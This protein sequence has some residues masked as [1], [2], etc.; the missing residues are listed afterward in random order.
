MSERDGD[1]EGLGPR[2]TIIIGAPIRKPRVQQ[3]TTQPFS[4]ISPRAGS[5][6]VGGLR[7]PRL[8]LPDSGLGS[9]GTPTDS[10]G[11]EKLFP[12]PAVP[13]DHQDLG[14]ADDS[15]S[16]TTLTFRATPGPGGSYSQL[17]SPY[18]EEELFAAAADIQS[19]YRRFRAQKLLSARRKIIRGYLDERQPDRVSYVIPLQSVF[20]RW[21]ATAHLKR[22]QEAIATYLLDLHRHVYV[23]PPADVAARSIRR[24][25]NFLRALV[26]RHRMRRQRLE[27]WRH[28]CILGIAA[29]PRIVPSPIPSAVPSPAARS[30]K[31]KGPEVF[32]MSQQAEEV[33][34][35]PLAEHRKRRDHSWSIFAPLEDAAWAVN[36][37]CL[38]TLEA[39]RQEALWVWEAYS[40]KKLTAIARRLQRW[41]RIQS[42]V[43]AARRHWNLSR[44]TVMKGE[45]D[46]THERC[47]IG[48]GH[49]LET[50]DIERCI[51]QLHEA[52]HRATL[53]Q[54]AD[55][56]AKDRR[57]L[58]E[59]MKL[60]Q[61]TRRDGVVLE[62]ETFLKDEVWPLRVQLLGLMA[63][64]GSLAIISHRQAEI[65]I[66]TADFLLPMATQMKGNLLAASEVIV[67]DVYQRGKFII[68]DKPAIIN[69]RMVRAPK[70]KPTRS[71]QLM[72]IETNETL[73]RNHLEH[74][75]ESDLA[76][77]MSFITLDRASA[78]VASRFSE[79]EH[80]AAVRKKRIQ[81]TGLRLFRPPSAEP[82][83]PS[84]PAVSPTKR[85][86]HARPASSTRAA[87]RSCDHDHPRD[88]G[89]GPVRIVERPQNS[90]EQGSTF[91]R[92]T[93]RLI[94]AQY[95]PTTPPDRYRSNHDRKHSR[96]A[97][98]GA[99]TVKKGA[100]TAGS[101]SPHA[102]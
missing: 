68:D 49:V 99:A 18:S 16:A 58:V 6:P 43:V 48:Q 98:T 57:A 52:A 32:P 14:S 55:W 38:P 51:F 30:K 5:S 24:I 37:E 25:V 21:L 44:S 54:F 97:L 100:T 2:T 79:M 63:D 34:P 82:M 22:R 46:E 80:N 59:L 3:N 28:H 76:L 95:H 56:E 65:F 67:V 8:L 83:F 74:R 101:A 53:K 11:S 23:P 42:K 39:M 69:G 12:R 71:E 33:R 20:R 10:A 102:K 31:S 88:P 77:L 72:N 45:L 47:S 78:L 87:P 64:D 4:P 19:V 62:Y 91:L 27:Q 66:I 36:T 73:W 50:E 35:Q 26:I 7:P 90:G 81:E 15:G 17:M 1:E 92:Q 41:W 9:G 29:P 93:L 40:R 60:E 96:G 61:S 94:T 85:P 13:P 84:H 89:K 75:E 70:Q 86:S